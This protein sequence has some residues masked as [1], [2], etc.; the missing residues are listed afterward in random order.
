M[1]VQSNLSKHIYGG[2]GVTTEFPFTFPITSASDIK[3]YYQDSSGVLNLLTSGYTVNWSDG[4]DSGS[5]T[6][7]VGGGSTIL[8]SGCKLVLLRVCDQLQLLDLSQT[9]GFKKEAI[10]RSL[11]LLTMIVQQ[12]SEQI[13]RA[14]KVD[15]VE[16]VSPDVLIVS[17]QNAAAAA[18]AAAAVSQQAMVLIGE[19]A[20]ISPGDAGKTIVV[21]ESENGFI[22]ANLVTSFLSLTDT[23]DSYS[24]Y[25]K[26]GVRVNSAGNAL[27][28][29]NSAS[30]LILIGHS[31]TYV[32]TSDAAYAAL[33]G[34]RFIH[35]SMR[36]QKVLKLAVIEKGNG[37]CRISVTDGTTSVNVVG[38]NQNVGSYAVQEME[39]DCSTLTTGLLWTV[40][41]EG[42]AVS[43]EYEMR[44][45]SCQADPANIL[46]G[47]PLIL[48]DPGVSHNTATPTVVD[49]PYWFPVNWAIDN[50][51]VVHAKG[52]LTLNS[53]TTATVKVRL[54]ATRDSETTYEEQSQTITATGSFDLLIAFPSIVA[55][56]VKT[57]VFL[58]TDG[59]VTLEHFE[60]WLEV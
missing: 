43:G 4:D 52:T 28:F 46:G 17:L 21:N 47:Y 10:E 22:L 29:A 32:C 35:D 18:V 16:T 19:I 30:N 53:G 39:L 31:N 55:P 24:G 57:E 13:E 34:M 25:A 15:V 8:P 37:N 36:T 49:R 20:S 50:Q 6:Y 33:L 3:V 23:P 11:D 2:N 14:V 45:F 54:T 38:T 26:K 27:E 58:S 40:T 48:A 51:C 41:I 44:H 9:N 12:L 60:C 5:V 42:Q 56:Y 59:M 7:P 1:T